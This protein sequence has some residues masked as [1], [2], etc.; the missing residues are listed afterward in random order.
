MYTVKGVRNSIWFCVRLLATMMT[1]WPL[2]GNTWPI[3]YSNSGKKHTHFLY[4]IVLCR[5]DDFDL[6]PL[7]FRWQ[8]CT[9]HGVMIRGSMPSEKKNQ[10]WLN[11]EQHIYIYT[12]TPHIYIE[13]AAKQM[14]SHASSILNNLRDCDNILCCT[15]CTDVQ[16]VEESMEKSNIKYKHTPSFIQ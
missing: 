9:V 1:E 6:L 13:F 11:C 5:P 15:N 8:N 3:T 16:K 4:Y 2:Y 12:H 14:I 7:S 10:H